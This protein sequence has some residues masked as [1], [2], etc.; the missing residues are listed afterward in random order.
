MTLKSY[1]VSHPEY[2]QILQDGQT[3]FGCNQDWYRIEWRRRAGCGPV[4]ATNIL[5]YLRKKY[6]ES[7]IPYSNISVED[8]LD[9]MNDVFQFVRPKRRGLHTVRKLVKGMSAFGRRYGL[10]FRYRYLLVPPQAEKRPGLGEVVR[11]IMEGLGNDVPVAFLNLHAGAVEEQ[12]SSWHWVTVVGITADTALGE[13][14]GNTVC[15]N[16]ADTAILRFYDQSKCLEVELDKWLSTTEKG[17]G[18]A[19]FYKPSQSNTIRYSARS[20]I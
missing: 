3:L 5:F 2:M 17:G 9:A 10:S 7:S 12:L 1:D 8:A 11:F 20:R 14:A 16:T 18:F 15:S 19:Y 4:A 13:E 6:D